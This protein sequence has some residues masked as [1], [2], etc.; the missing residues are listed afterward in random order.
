MSFGGGERTRVIVP[1]AP[2]RAGSIPRIE[3]CPKPR[4][5]LRCELTPG[6]AVAVEKARDLPA[7]LLELEGE[8]CIAPPPPLHFGPDQR[9]CGGGRGAQLRTATSRFHPQGVL[10]TD[11]AVNRHV[12][13]DARGPLPFVSMSA[14]SP[15]EYSSLGQRIAHALQLET[16]TQTSVETALMQRHPDLFPHRGFLSS[17]I[18]GRRGAK[19]P[20]PVKIKAIADFL[21]VQ[22]EWLLIGTGEIRRDGRATTPAEMAMMTARTFGIR[23]DAWE[24]AWERNKDRADSMSAEDWFDAIRVEAEKLTRAGIPRPEEEAAKREKQA[25]IRRMKQKKYD[26]TKET[27]ALLVAESAKK[28]AYGGG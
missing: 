9:Q 15:S 6:F 26:V 24:V 10:S 2:D 14:S 3:R 16:R 21:H 18:S 13:A 11:S 20:D 27:P 28:R 22:F 17:Y 4:E 12:L 7:V 25:K 23:E 5:K 19:A 8:A 1:T